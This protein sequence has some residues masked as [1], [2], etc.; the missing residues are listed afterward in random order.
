[1]PLVSPTGHNIINTA[2]PEA[3]LP[4]SVAVL[5]QSSQLLY[6]A[7]LGA[8]VWEILTTL[9]LDYQML[10][11]KQV[12]L[13]TVA[14]M[15]SRWAACAHS[16]AFVVFASARLPHHFCQHAI[17]AFSA[18]HAI[19][20]P[21]TALLLYLRAMALYRWNRKL[22]MLLGTFW[23]AI[24]ATGIAA[25]FALS[26]IEIADTKRCM[27]RHADTFAKAPVIALFLHDTV[28][29][30]AVSARILFY[31]IPNGQWGRQAF[32]K[33]RREGLTPIVAELFKQGTLYYGLVDVHLG[34]TRQLRS[35]R[36][37]NSVVVFM[38]ILCFCSLVVPH[39]H[40]VAK[41]ML[42]I[43]NLAVTASMGGR[44]HR[45]MVFATTRPVS[46]I[47]IDPRAKRMSSFGLR[48]PTSPRNAHVDE[49]VMELPE[50]RNLASPRAPSPAIPR[51]PRVRIHDQSRPRRPA[52]PPSPREAIS[53][54]KIP[55]I[56]EAAGIAGDDMDRRSERALSSQA[57]TERLGI[58]GETVALGLTGSR[59]EEGVGGL[60]NAKTSDSDTNGAVVP[61]RSER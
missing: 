48:S 17:A 56:V 20:G 31:D 43:P 47:A 12:T 16:I 53:A 27:L 13:G 39:A 10:F 18:C 24:L 32:Q 54:P 4:D 35:R 19:A 45:Q 51:S 21:S 2:W 57:E 23:L 34:R 6:S 25:P 30:L 3:Y 58:P 9:H 52:Y 49:A 42:A 8:Q 40:P 7:V 60:D 44:V 1:M 38:N 50:R 36:C 61:I 46:W 11:R 41:L 28:V 59:C 29:W 55:S 26:A 33:H 5:R 37:S 22:A 14:Y 15:A